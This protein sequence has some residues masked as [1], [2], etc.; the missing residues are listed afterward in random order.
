MKAPCS[1]TLTSQAQR[2]CD[3]DEFIHPQPLHITA[4]LQTLPRQ[5]ATFGEFRRAMLVDIRAHP[6]LIDW[7]ARTDDD[8][9]IMLLEMWAYVCD[10]L[11]FYDEIIAHEIYLRTA[12]LQPSLRKL[13]SL[14]GY[15]P[16]PAI[17]ATANL[18]L[19]AEG[20]QPVVLPKGTAFRS[21][22]FNGQPPQVFELA[23]EATI[24]PLFNHWQL[25]SPRADAL[26]EANPSSLL[27]QP[28]FL[29]DVG[30]VIFL[31]VGSQVSLYQA[32][33]V[34]AVMAE[35]VEGV[36]NTQ[37]VTFSPGLALPVG[38][39]HAQMR[40]ETPT[41]S[42]RLWTVN[43]SLLAIEAAGSTT[44]LTLDK[45][46]ADIKAGD[47][48]LV[49]QGTEHRWFRVTTVE[50]VLR[51][52]SA[53]STIVI[54]GNNFPTPAITVPVTSIT[55][56]V[57][58]N[59]NSRKGPGGGAWNNNQ[60]GQIIVQYGLVPAGIVTST[61]ETDLE[62]NDSLNV[63][64]R[65]ESPPS[66]QLPSS[67]ALEDKNGDGVIIGGS[68]NFATGQL[69]LD[70]GVSWQ[71]SLIN[72]VQLYGN[73][74]LASRGESVKVEI[75]GSGDASQAN[76]SFKLKKKPLTYI[77]AA[78]GSGLASS[79]QIRV[80]G[81]L[82]SEVPSFFN[83]KRESQVYIVRQN[84]DGES[85][86]TFGDGVRGARLPTGRDN[87][88]ASYRFGAGVASPPA[89]SIT[90]LARPVKGLRS[91]RNPVA[92]AG[93]ADA[94]TSD[95]L[96][97]YAPRSALLLGRAVSIQDMEAVA[98]S[99]PG[100]RAVSSEWRWHGVSQRP[101][102]QIWYIGEPGIE[103]TVLQSLQALSDPTTPIN[104]ERALGVPAY[105]SLDIEID[106]RHIAETV[107]STIREVLTDAENGLL[108]PE[109]IGIGAPLY[110]SR[111]FDKVL[112]VT[113]TRTVRDILWDGDRFVN[114]AV[115]PRA[116][117]YFDLEAGGL[118]LN[119][120]Q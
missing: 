11:A 92:A 110:R 10:V 29:L 100:V 56:D 66:G 26:R 25:Q 62:S 112:E 18:A 16:R 61:P 69:T 19:F 68:L 118:L 12:R 4:G 87:V 34:S 41:R 22:A 37:R 8:L 80:E 75:L 27:V 71:P 98:A 89:Q 94:E 46:Y 95:S 60:R 67:F 45:Q 64:G 54:N 40:L 3:C 38:T 28:S 5:I 116:G 20:R 51:Q 105:L 55:L 53:G 36:P 13:V 99:V 47:T 117:S 50:E 86:V 21:A 78:S 109:R 83:V 57:E 9:G 14:I 111:I 42:A 81:I 96:R 63:E 88:T 93:G 58:L 79:L 2:H 30:Q 107:L 77:T 119:G 104:V 65:L 17:A 101:G 15:V 35:A 70:G 72:P 85:V 59:T 44:R 103:Q 7:R 120:R 106:T 23:S 115:R 108:A 52:T 32:R 102:V 84:N 48:V 91:V 39:L 43:S 82:W 114:F 97:T 49:S 90:Q 24:Q 73:V 113:G 33:Q 76:Q 6:A 1:E 31:R 74:V